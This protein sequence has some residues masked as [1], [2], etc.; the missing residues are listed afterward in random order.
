M[1]PGQT[2]PSDEEIWEMAFENNFIPPPRHWTF[3]DQRV[4]FGCDLYHVDKAT[5]Y[6]LALLDLHSQYWETTS[7]EHLRRYHRGLQYHVEYNFRSAVDTSTY[8]TPPFLKD[9]L[10]R[11]IFKKEHDRNGRKMV[12]SIL[13][14]ISKN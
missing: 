5:L 12:E 7:P 11:V 4:K 14:D 13:K 2:S 9:W 10:V 8:R 3:D 6:E 1:Q